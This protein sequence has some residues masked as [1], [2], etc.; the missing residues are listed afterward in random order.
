MI[1]IWNLGFTLHMPNMFNCLMLFSAVTATTPIN[2]R[3]HVQD[4]SE[5][6]RMLGDSGKKGVV[7][8]SKVK[9]SR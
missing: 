5:V 6:V 3:G 1:V 7:G 2:T 9:M 4:T 8:P